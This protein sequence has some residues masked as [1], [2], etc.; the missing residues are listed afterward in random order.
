MEE[1]RLGVDIGRVLIAGPAAGG[2]DTAFFAGD[3]AAMLATPEVP[4]AV[5]ALAD[6]VDRLDGR[7]WLVS[8]CGPR[9]QARTRRWLAAHDVHRRTGIRPADVRFCLRRPQKRE[10]CLE[11][12]LTDFVDDRADV[13][14]A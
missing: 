2:P 9:V 12:G 7:V 10:H 5:D 1:I 3:E 4:G 8:K 13:H 11:L 14:A 6:L